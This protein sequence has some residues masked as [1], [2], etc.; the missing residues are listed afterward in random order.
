M[1]K[2]FAVE[3]II[4]GFITTWTTALGQTFTEFVETEPE[5]Y[6]KLMGALEVYSANKVR[7][8]I[9]GT[10]ITKAKSP[11]KWRGF[12]QGFDGEFPSGGQR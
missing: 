4:N 2:L 9:T 3:E 1:K 7:P 12:D 6:Y 8:S 11:R 10:H 5:A